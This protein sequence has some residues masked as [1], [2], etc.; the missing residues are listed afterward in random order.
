MKFINFKKI[1]KSYSVI[2]IPYSNDNVRRISFNAPVAKL[3]FVLLAVSV[4]TVSVFTYNYQMKISVSGQQ[5]QEASSAELEAQ[6]SYLTQ[7]VRQQNESLSLRNN[8]LDRM[9]QENSDARAKI[10]EF[11]KLYADIA[12]DYLKKNS[13]GTS[14][15]K[16]NNNTVMALTKLG[17]IV[18]ELNNNF[19]TNRNL[20]AE[21]LRTKQKLEKY[22][23][24]IPTYLPASGAIG[25][26]FGMRNHPIQKVYKIHEGVDISSSKGQPIF[27]AASGVV[28]YS[29]YSDGYGYNI[30]IDHK[31]GFRTIYGHSSKLLVKKGDIITKGQ[32]IA[33]IGSTGNSTGPHLHFEI[34]I[35]NTPVNPT[36]YIVFNQVK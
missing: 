15:A 19:N 25:S 7:V 14:S 9:A 24:Y 36:E 21:L 30:K 31:N 27:A 1:S 17:S 28:E 4:I 8:Q 33:L 5:L 3:L 20:G 10:E 2:V 34:R 13:R 22:L 35:G 26:P 18:Q 6:I 32:K 16:G 23:D 29:G 12:D 11:T